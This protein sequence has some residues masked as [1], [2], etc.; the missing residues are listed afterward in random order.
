MTSD[1][2]KKIHLIYYLVVHRLLKSILLSDATLSML[3]QFGN[4][5][6]S[7]KAAPYIGELT[8]E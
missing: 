2:T 3:I 6:F 4:T 5:F 7:F 1:L 8:R